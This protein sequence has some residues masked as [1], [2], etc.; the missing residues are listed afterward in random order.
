MDTALESLLPEAD[1]ASGGA[2]GLTLRPV[3]LSGVQRL[4][5]RLPVMLSLQR[6][7]CRGASRQ[8]CRHCTAGGAAGTADTNAGQRR[9]QA[10]ATMRRQLFVARREEK[11]VAKE[12]QM[13]SAFTLR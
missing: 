9:M 7:G 2:G 13:T 1:N 5:G 8:A 12:M 4:S 3:R 11:R 6:R 10:G